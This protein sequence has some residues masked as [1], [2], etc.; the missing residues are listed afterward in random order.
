MVLMFMR[1]KNGIFLKIIVSLIFKLICVHFL[2]SHS[3]MHIYNY[4]F[5]DIG[6]FNFGF[7]VKLYFLGLT[8]NKSPHYY[9]LRSVKFE[10]GIE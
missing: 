4:I 5:I 6:S 2:K 7:K 9:T 10:L 3:F 1:Y 8:E